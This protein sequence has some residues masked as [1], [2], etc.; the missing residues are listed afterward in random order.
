MKAI[1]LL[2]LD[3][4]KNGQNFLSLLHLNSLIQKVY[5]VQRLLTSSHLWNTVMVSLKTNAM[6]S[7]LLP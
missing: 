7:F 4:A 3:T 1:V 2:G 5:D 6:S